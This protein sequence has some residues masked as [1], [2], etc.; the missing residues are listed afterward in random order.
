LSTPDL[1]NPIGPSGF[2]VTPGEVHAAAVSVDRTAAEIDAQLASLKTYVTD[3]EERWGGIA[4]ATFA[5]LMSDYH[6]QSLK[7][8]H[9]LVSIAGG[10][11]TTGHE[12]SGSE[13][14]NIGN[15][16]SVHAELPPS[17]F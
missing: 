8:H 6:V 7:L 11:R 1:Q 17:R 5:G 13:L 12:Y 16:H 14:A 3:L 15:L 9:A 4:Q 2:R 10:L